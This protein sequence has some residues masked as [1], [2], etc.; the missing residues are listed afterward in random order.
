MP[1]ELY[2]AVGEGAARRRAAELAERQAARHKAAV[3]RR[4]KAKRG[5]KR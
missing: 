2:A 5:G 4:R 1:W 3:A